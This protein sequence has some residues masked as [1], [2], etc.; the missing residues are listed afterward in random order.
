MSKKVRFG[1]RPP[2]APTANIPPGKRDAAIDAWVN[3]E[4]A[5]GAEPVKRFTFEVPQS[6]HR[7]IKLQCTA[8]G[9]QMAEVLREMLEERF[10]PDPRPPQHRPAANEAV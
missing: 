10:P 6:L 8:Q 1:A 9:R 7:R 4:P 5:G 2:S 3:N